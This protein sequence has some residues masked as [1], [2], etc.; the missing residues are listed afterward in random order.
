MTAPSSLGLE[1]DYAHHTPG[2][3]AGF[4]NNARKKI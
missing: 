4:A 3:V 1:E 2:F